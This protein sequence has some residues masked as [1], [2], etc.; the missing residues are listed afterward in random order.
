M[1]ATAT[2][3]HPR[4]APALAGP[5]RRGRRRPLR[6]A[7]RLDD[8]LVAF[9]EPARQHLGELVVG[10]AGTEAHGRDLLARR[11]VGLRPASASFAVGAGA[12]RAAAGAARPPCPAGAARAARPRLARRLPGQ[13]SP[14]APA[15]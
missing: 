12:R 15:A 5:L 6:A 9:L 4:A 3:E 14:P 7:R 8:D 10:D 1:S 2:L 13:L 11:F